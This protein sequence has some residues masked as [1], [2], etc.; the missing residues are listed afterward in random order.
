MFCFY[1]SH[2]DLKNKSAFWLIHM[3]LGSLVSM[4]LLP[5]H[6]PLLSLLTEPSFKITWLEWYGHSKKCGHPERTFWPTKHSP[7]KQVVSQWFSKL[8]WMTDPNL[9]P[10]Y[11]KQKTELP[12][13]DTERGAW[14]IFPDY[15]PTNVFSSQMAH[16]N[17]ALLEIWKPL[18]YLGSYQTIDVSE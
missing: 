16:L 2:W 3:V 12:L 10:C 18:F 13:V 9:K 15:S 6:W 7:P 5:R 11:V 1:A 17:R 4:K 14:E 8:C